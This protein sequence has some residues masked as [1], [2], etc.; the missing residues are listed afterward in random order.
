MPLGHHNCCG[1]LS[2]GIVKM[3]ERTYYDPS[4]IKDLWRDFL[5]PKC[6]NR[7]NDCIHRASQHNKDGCT[8]ESADEQYN[9]YSGMTRIVYKRCECK[10]DP[11]EVRL[12]RRKIAK[13]AATR[14]EESLTQQLD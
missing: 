13:N 6:P 8:V 9:N 4:F 10:L 11:A 12:N 7:H 5:D 2:L 1:F 14:Y 3:D